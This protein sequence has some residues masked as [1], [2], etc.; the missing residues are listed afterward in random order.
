M[1]VSINFYDEGQWKVPNTLTNKHFL[2][3]NRDVD[4]LTRFF[5]KLMSLHSF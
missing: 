4:V 5:T 1:Y 2:G 3:R